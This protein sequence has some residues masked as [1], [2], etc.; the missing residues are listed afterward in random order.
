M[1]LGKSNF[2]GL[3]IEFFFQSAWRPFVISRCGHCKRLKPEFEKA[4]DILKKNDPVITLAKVD[5]T[6][7]GKD[8]CNKF[9]V[10]GYPTLKIF[11]N[12]ELSQEYSGPREAQGI[13]KYMQ[14]QVGPSSK[15][16]LTQKDFEKFI[17]K[18]DVVVVGFFEK[19]SSLK[20][21]FLKAADKLREKVRFGHASN[22]DI[23]DKVQFK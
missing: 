20:D 4:G 19:E 23:L 12:G 15:E 1:P 8:T 7:A 10:T 18:D 6:E 22:S 16:L 17:D 3:I 9:S 14:S 21:A 13:V 5:C 2:N 11:K